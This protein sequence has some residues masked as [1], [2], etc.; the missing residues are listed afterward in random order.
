METKST[1]GGRAPARKCGALTQR[2]KGP[3]CKR[4]RGW[5]TDHPGYGNCKRHGGATP[6]GKAHAAKEAAMIAARED[7]GGDVDIDPIEA[8]LHTVRRGAYLAK[9]WQRAAL[10]AETDEAFAEAAQ[11]EARA[12]ADLN[13]W[14]KAAVDGGVA[15]RQVQIAERL[16]DGVVAA[17]EEALAALE[18]ALGVPLTVQQRTAY[19][20]ALGQ[21]L[22]RL[23]AG[24]IEATASD[25]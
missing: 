15:E 7:F 20:A 24:T 16:A 18:A 13:R 5:G 19:A 1:R 22:G 12:L 23:E 14:A 6:S 10:A 3:P 4:G 2:G 8:L 21:G 17:A 11:Q 9:F 25:T